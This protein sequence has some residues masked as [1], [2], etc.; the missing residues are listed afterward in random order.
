MTANNSRMLFVNL[1][2]RD[3]KRSMDFF[4]RLG[5]KFN[6]QFTTEEAA[7]MIIGKDAYAMLL[8]ED[9]FS[10]FAK[11]P[12][13]DATRVTGG[14]YAVMVSSRDE[15]DRMVHEALAAGG[16]PAADKMD[17]GPMYGWSFY[18][19]DGHHWEV[20]WMDPAVVQPV[21]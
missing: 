8:R 19:P 11:K 18:D 4:T 3:P 21:G 7:C 10:T 17:Q 2:V 15:V 6:P 9:F 13:P 12:V 1:P 5:F 16:S 14:L 20:G